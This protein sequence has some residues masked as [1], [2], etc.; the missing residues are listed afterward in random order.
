MEVI[1]RQQISKPD[2]DQCG[3]AA[4]SAYN[5][6]RITRSEYNLLRERAL[7]AGYKRTP[8]QLHVVASRVPYLGLTNAESAAAKESIEQLSKV[9]PRQFKSIDRRL[10]A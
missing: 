7:A 8:A 6:K 4:A 10:A 1:L 9:F 3:N 5:E 2:F